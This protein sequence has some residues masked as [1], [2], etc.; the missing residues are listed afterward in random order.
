[1]TVVVVPNP[2]GQRTVTV[3]VPGP[4]GAQGATGAQGPTGATGATGVQGPTGPTGAQGPIGPTGATGAT[5]PIGPTGATGATGATGPQGPSLN[6]VESASTIAALTAPQQD[7]IVQGTL[8]TTTDGRRWVYR[9]TGDKTLEASYVQITQQA[10]GA[11]LLSGAN[12]QFTGGTINGVA[13]G[14]TTPAAG[15][16]TTVTSSGQITHAPNA[17]PGATLIGAL[18]TNPAA[19]AVN[20]AVELDFRP[21][22]AGGARDATIR[23][24]QDVSGNYADL[25]FL[26]AGSDTP[27][28][29][30]KLSTITSAPDATFGSSLAS[31]MNIGLDASGQ[32]DFQF[33]R[34]GSSRWLMRR[35]GDA[36]SGANAGSNWQ[37]LARDDAGASIDTPFSVTRAAGGAATLNRPLVIAGGPFSAA[38]VNISQST[39]N[40]SGVVY[41]GASTSAD[42]AEVRHI[43]NAG[44]HAPAAASLANLHDILS[45]SQ[46]VGGSSAITTWRGIRSRSNQAAG[47]TGTVNTLRQFEASAPTWV[48]GPVA[49]YSAFI[50]NQPSFGAQPT[51]AS[52]FRGTLTAATGR[53]NA[54]MDG[55]ARNFFRGGLDIGAGAAAALSAPIKLTSGTLMTTPEPGSLEYDGNFKFT[56]SAAQRLTFSGTMSQAQASVGNAAGPETALRTINYVAGALFADGQSSE[57]RATLSFVNN[58]NTKTITVKFG[59]TGT[60]NTLYTGNITVNTSGT[61]EIIIHVQ[62]ESASSVRAS[63][64]VISDDAGLKKHDYTLVTG[65][66]LANAQALTIN[67]TSATANNV[68]FRFGKTIFSGAA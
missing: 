47:F 24:V 39:T 27:Q 49:E 60:E 35:T 31:T 22:G 29:A 15:S 58:A 68:N 59:P 8:V 17:S 1:M 4:P 50:A 19:N 16:F 37:L 36:E 61:L 66:T 14:G 33:R 30:L 10:F 64:S 63:V 51:L 40:A 26:V 65:L 2:A 23:S 41:Q 44:T 6:I 54:Y 57:S 21:N 18:L 46:L 11:L 13:I 67:A 9:G 12:V 5:G 48:A 62:R 52:A 53:W 3:Q 20:T 56:L 34:N 55:T 32:S 28:R 42:A 43:Y 45:L 25:Q 7:L 38:S